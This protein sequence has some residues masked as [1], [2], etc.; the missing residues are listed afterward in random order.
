MALLQTRMTL[1]FRPD[2][3]H[4]EITCDTSGVVF[5]LAEIPAQETLELL[6]HRG[7]VR[8]AA[9]VEHLDKVGLQHECERF[10]FPMPRVR[11]SISVKQRDQIAFETAKRLCPPGWEPDNY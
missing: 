11:T 4:L 10:E 8:V 7:C 2:G 9:R 6:S 1:Q 5:C 3:L